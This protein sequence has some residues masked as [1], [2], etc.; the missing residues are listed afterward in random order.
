MPTALNILHIQNFTITD[1]LI[2]IIIKLNETKYFFYLNG[3]LIEEHV[4]LM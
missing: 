4:I 3:N 2:E 1:W